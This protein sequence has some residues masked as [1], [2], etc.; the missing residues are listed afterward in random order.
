MTNFCNNV[1]FNILFTG[2]V[3]Y[4][5]RIFLHCHSPAEHTVILVGC[6][7]HVF[8]RGLCSVCSVNLLPARYSLKRL[9]PKQLQ[10]LL[11]YDRVLSFCY[12]PILAGI[13]YWVQLSF[14][15]LQ[16]YSC[17]SN[18]RC[19]C[20]QKERFHQVRELQHCFL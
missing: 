6:V 19:I 7:L 11:L 14:V 9:I 5:K 10:A 20:S 1:M 4:T 8:F 18:S 2:D 13:G 12:A 15:F 3:L 16:K 17:Y